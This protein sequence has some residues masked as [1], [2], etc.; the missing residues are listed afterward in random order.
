MGSL[1]VLVL[2][3]EATWALAKWLGIGGSAMGG[4]NRMDA[5]ATGID[6]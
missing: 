1:V 5:L 3:Q 2:R 4:G 6:A